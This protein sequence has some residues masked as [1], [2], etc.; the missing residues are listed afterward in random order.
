M[1]SPAFAGGRISEDIKQKKSSGKFD[2]YAAEL[3]T[4]AP[5]GKLNLSKS[6]LPSSTIALDIKTT[7]IAKTVREQPEHISVLIPIK[8]KPVKIL[9]Y[10]VPNS[11]KI[12]TNQNPKAIT[13]TALNYRGIA[14]T[15]H[16]SDIATITFSDGQVLGNL[17]INGENFVLQKALQKNS[18]MEKNDL[19]NKDTHAIYLK[20]DETIPPFNCEIRKPPV[21]QN[22][23]PGETSTGGS[24][25]DNLDGSTPPVTSSILT[26]KTVKVYVETGYDI[27][28][29]K[30]STTNVD[31]YI[32]GVFNQITALYYNDDVSVSLKTV[33]IWT[34]ADPYAGLSSGQI[35]TNFGSTT[36][37]GRGTGFDGDVAMFINYSPYNGGIAYVDTLCLS[38]QIKTSYCGIS[39]SFA[40]YPTYSWTVECMSHELGHL[41]GSNHTHACSWNGNNTSIDGCAPTYNVGLKEGNCAI[42][43]IPTKGTIMSYCHLLSNVGIDFT[44]GFGPQPKAVITGNVNGAS[45]LANSGTCTD[46]TA[47]TV[48]ITSP[49]NSATISGAS[50]AFNTTAFDAGQVSKIELFIDNVLL[51]TNF[52]GTYNYTLNTTSYSNGAHVLTAKA[53]DTCGNMASI[54]IDVN[55]SN[56]SATDMIAPT[57]SIISPTNGFV[58]RPKVN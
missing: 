46:V 57:V 40:T 15:N 28:T 25:G 17:I 1:L 48:T 22:L 36:A 50:V 41:L 56:T 23:S 18:T 45:C 49:T 33:F 31:T 7:A 29:N 43:P 39:S 5:A 4:V 9:L 53:Y 58:I 3:F 13:S 52:S 27:F 21:R 2:A 54:S 38:P 51:G 20:K 16:D 55:I 11:T 34:T 19:A 14:D 42:G 44:L 47:P 26:S 6:K 8:N 10:R 35:L 32:Q 12:I 30:G 37:P 24:S